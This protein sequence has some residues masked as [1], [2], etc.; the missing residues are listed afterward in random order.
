[1]FMS[2]AFSVPFNFNKTLLYKS[3]WVI[4]TGPKVKSLEI[5]S[6]TPFTV[7]Y[8]LGGLSRIFSTRKEH[9]LCGFM[10]PCNA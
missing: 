6:L 7:N 8:H 10:V 2:E 4:K 3:S 5:T 1:M 9:V